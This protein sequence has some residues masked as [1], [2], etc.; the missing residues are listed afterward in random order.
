MLEEPPQED[1][2]VDPQIPFEVFAEPTPLMKGLVPCD[3]NIR[4][5][6]I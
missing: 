5:M 6:L 4:P 1:W 3:V 2:A